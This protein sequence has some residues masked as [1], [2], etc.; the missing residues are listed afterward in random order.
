MKTVALP[1]EGRIM[2]PLSVSPS[3]LLFGTLAPGQSATK[4]IVLSGK[5][6]F[7]VV[8]IST[9]GGALQF[10]VSTEVSKKVHLVPITVTAP[11][12]P[13]EF[14]YTLAIDTDL[15]GAGRATCII[16][17]AVRGDSPTAATRSRPVDTLPVR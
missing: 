16:R 15:I 5:Q 8:S 17:G 6:P 13:G 10:K 1:I 12:Q 9:D 4:P 7:K 14:H 2:P 11:H 3:P